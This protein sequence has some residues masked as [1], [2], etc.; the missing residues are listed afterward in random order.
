MAIVTDIIVEFFLSMG[1]IQTSVILWRFFGS[2]NL[3]WVTPTVSLG[4]AA[5]MVAGTWSSRLSRRYMRRRAD[6]D[7]E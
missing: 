1:M 7:R 4:A 6:S 3:D 5:L 2:A